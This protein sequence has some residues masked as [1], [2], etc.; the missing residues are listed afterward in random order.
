MKRGEGQEEENNEFSESS[1][2]LCWNYVKLA[3]P[4][5]E[6]NLAFNTLEINFHELAARFMNEIALA[7]FTRGGHKIHEQNLKCTLS[8]TVTKMNK[9][10]E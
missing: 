8:S 6:W 3:Y 4:R 9:Y 5:R 7:I 2:S 10:L 1:L